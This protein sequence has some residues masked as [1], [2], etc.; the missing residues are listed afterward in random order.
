LAESGNPGHPV[1]ARF[2]GLDLY[3]ASP[4]TLNAPQGVEAEYLCTS[5]ADAWSMGEPFYTNPEI[6]YL[7]ERDAANTRGRKILGASLAGT[8]PSWFN[9]KPRPEPEDGSELADMPPQ[10]K[11]ARII[12]IGDTEF[13]TSFIN[14]SNGQ[15][16]LDFMVQV[17]DWLCNDDDIIGIRSRASGSGRLDKIIEPAKKTS[18]MK[19]AQLINVYIVPLLVILAGVLLA[20]KRRAEANAKAR[21]YAEENNN[22]TDGAKEHSDGL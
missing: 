7:F 5:T 18:A 13:A 10:A 6:P 8:F 19:F 16:N 15:R 3:W 9:G 17:A 12:V 1:S 2:N 20:L 4:L 21:S 11:P 22:K 14:V